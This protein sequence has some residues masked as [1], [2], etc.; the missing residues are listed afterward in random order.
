M[1]SLNKLSER[2]DNVK[3]IDRSEKV[4]VHF[5]QA[6]W[7]E[8]I[9]YELSTPGER[10]ILVGAPDEEIA[11]QTKGVDA[12]PEGMKRN[13]KL[14]LPELS[15]S[16]VLRHYA[17]LAQQTLGAD[18]NIE[19]GQ[20]TCTVKYS[21]KVNEQLSALIRE[22][23]PLQ[24]A[25]TVQG[26]LEIFHE[27]DKY[28]SEISGM[29]HFTFQPGGGSQGILT[30]ASVMRAYFK[31]K[32]E[33]R[34]EIITTIYSHPSDA[35]APAVAGFKIVYLQPD[36]KTGVPD[37]EQLKAAA[38]PKTAGYIVANPE[39]TG[40]YNSHVKEFVDYIHS[41]GGLCGYDQANAN[42]LLGITRARDAGF[43]MCFFNLHK[44]FS[45]PHGCGGP[46]CG[47][48]GVQKDLVQYLPAP[49]VDYDGEKYFLNYDICSNPCAGG[50][51]RE[52]Y[53]WAP[54]VLKAYCWIRSMGP[55]GLYQVA[56]TAVL[57]NNY[58]FKKLMEL[59]EVTAY[60]EDG[61]NQRIEQARY[62]LETMEKETGISTLDIQRRMMDFG[63]HYWTS[64]HP[65]YLPEPMTLE[66]TETPSK[67]DI[68]EYIETL[69][70]VFKEAHENPDIIKTAPHRSVTHQ[71][72]ESGM[73]DPARWATTWKMYLKK[74]S[75]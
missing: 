7:D 42:G 63:M 30:M 53:G 24:D 37:L 18:V 6:K 41:I 31:D 1:K 16:R 71:V 50:K 22:Y 58:M 48:T 49:I 70:Y 38:G 62:S 43:D 3:R 20:G 8:P 35:A 15:Q 66:P 73:D 23:H 5:H 51:V 33:D 52:W 56:K 10:G 60:Y 57:N 44:T 61:N 19:I 12:L 36:E 72:D 21:P 34:D 74:Y 25:D 64:H 32:G 27:T 45:T 13:T 54:V 65:F 59:P 9:I 17:R 11:G 14:N 47:A 67:K 55:D 40:V 75:D 26:M 4:R 46:A 68:D 29:D 28:M 39:D 2:N 69:K